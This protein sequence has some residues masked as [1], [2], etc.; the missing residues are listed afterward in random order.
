MYI[1][2]GLRPTSLA[3]PTQTHTASTVSPYTCLAGTYTRTEGD[4]VE[5]IFDWETDCSVIGTGT[6][7]DTG[8]LSA[9]PHNLQPG[10]RH[11]KRA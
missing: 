1:G 5:I 9:T 11:K 3:I 6:G 7:T 8:D 10:N 2:V 4:D